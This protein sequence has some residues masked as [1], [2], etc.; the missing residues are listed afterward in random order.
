MTAIDRP[1]GYDQLRQLDRYLSNQR[2]VLIELAPET[3]WSWGPDPTLQFG[4]SEPDEA[5]PPRPCLKQ[6]GYL[7]CKA[8]TVR[9][10]HKKRW[11]V[12]DVNDR[13]AWHEVILDEATRTRAYWYPTLRAYAVDRG[14]S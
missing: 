1:L 13:Q 14:L 11:Y 12:G 5:P 7:L 10:R 6:R 4:S 2:E 3:R 9:V 8:V